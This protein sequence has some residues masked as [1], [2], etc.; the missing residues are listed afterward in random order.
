MPELKGD[1]CI[2]IDFKKDSPNP[3]R[4]FQTMSELIKSFQKLDN[5][6]IDSIDSN[7]E[8]IVLLEDIETGSLKTW[9]KTILKKIPDDSLMNIEWKQVLGQ[10]LV[11]AKYIVLNKLEGK[12]IITDAKEIEDIQYEIL[13]EAEKTEVHSFPTY[14]PI[15][16]K[17]LIDSIVD[18]NKS[19]QYLDKEDKAS[20]S[21]AITQPAMFN[22]EL[23]ITPENL[24]DLLTHEILENNVTMILKVNKPDY[25]GDSMWTL[26]HEQRTINAK[27]TDKAWLFQF[28]QRKV[29]V[30][31]GD[32]LK[33]EVKVIVKYGKDMT[34]LKTVYEITKIINT[35]NFDEKG[36][37]LP[38]KNTE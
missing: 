13:E 6:L 4:I 30:R 1:Y 24:E 23:N 14:A 2:T 26:K 36:A 18:I 22:L 35:I 38:F 32:S 31:P 34:V 5:V 10:F 33:C 19:L 15:Q 7:I 17:K 9:L 27:I 28:Q 11:K 8:P 21:S 12:T 25:L 20:F 16:P 3:E 37:Q 29:D